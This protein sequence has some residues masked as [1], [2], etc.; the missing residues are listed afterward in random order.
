MWPGTNV[1]IRKTLPTHVFDYDHN[2]NWTQAIDTVISWMNDPTAPANLVMVYFDEPD[3]AAHL[4]GPFSEE[5]KE[6]I[7][8]ADDT[9]GYL[10]QRLTNSD[11]LEATNLIVLSDH[12]MSEIEPTRVIQLNNLINRTL[13]EMHGASP[14]WNIIPKPGHEDEVYQILQNASKTNNFT[15]YKRD[16]TPHEYHYRFNRRIL[17]L[18]VVADDTFDIIDTIDN[19]G[20]EKTHKRW[21][22][23]GYNNSL[24]SM[25]PLFIAHGPAFKEHLVHSISFD[26]VDLYPLMCYVLQMLPLSSFPSNGTFSHVSDMLRPI[27]RKADTAPASVL[28]VMLIFFGGFAVICLSGTCFVLVTGYGYKKKPVEVSWGECVDQMASA[29]C[30]LCRSGCH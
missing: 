3:A 9:V 20:D 8:R 15:V 14:L 18:V 5:V 26:N 16:E 28:P 11:L 1:Y 7:H 13:Y 6:Q 24:A 25:T 12:G 2:A 23:H 17:D 10:L 27:V 29:N 21:G 30:P 4:F 22:N 19:L